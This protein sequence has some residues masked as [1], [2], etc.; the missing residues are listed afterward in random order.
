MA[1]ISQSYA[2]LGVG[3]YQCGILLENINITKGMRHSDQLPELGTLL[4]RQL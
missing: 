3:T 2:Q 4:Y 1:I